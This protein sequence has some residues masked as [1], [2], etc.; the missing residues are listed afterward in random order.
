MGLG[1]ELPVPV[2]EG[3]GQVEPAE[4]VEIHS[5]EGRVVDDVPPTQPIVELQPVKHTGSI[6]ETEDVLGEEI[7]V[8]VDDPACRDALGEQGGP[9]REIAIRELLDARDHSGVERP[10]D[11][12]RE[13]PQIPIPEVE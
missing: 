2:E 7:A 11:V 10:R 9:A 3:Q 6:I 5:E 1:R 4:P 12:R 8:P 13:L